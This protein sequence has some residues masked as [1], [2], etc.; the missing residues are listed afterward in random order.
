LPLFSYF[1][2][3]N[4]CRYIIRSGFLCAYLGQAIIDSSHMD[5]H[6]AP[7]IYIIALVSV[8]V[9]S[10]KLQRVAAVSVKK[11]INFVQ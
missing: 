7:L 10:I 8:T 1:F 2:K 11:M 9:S 4:L 6:V 3:I 5:K